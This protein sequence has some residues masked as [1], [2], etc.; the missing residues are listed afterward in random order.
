MIYIDSDNAMGSP[1]G[2]V[3]DGYAIAALVRANETV[4]GLGSTFGNTSEARAD[5]NNRRLARVCG[6]CGEFVRGARHAGDLDTEAARF[7]EQLPEQTRLALLG[8]VTNAVRAIR[9][10]KRFS[11]V[12]LVGSNS[13]SRGKWPPL[14]PHEFNLTLDGASSLT[15]FDSDAP[16]TLFPRGVVGQLQVSREMIGQLRGDAGNIIRGDSR[17]WLVRVLLVK[18]ALRFRVADLVAAAYMVAPHLFVMKETTATM[19]GNTFMKYGEGK[20]RVRVAAAFD[21]AAVWKLFV[22]LVNG[23]ASA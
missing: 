12:V 1:F 6:W 14:W 17:R 4:V 2:D 7:I 19:D 22:N 23:S 16:L 9:S 13:S 21:A 10:G 18:Q 15:L 8:P 5:K 3:D 20:G 11:E